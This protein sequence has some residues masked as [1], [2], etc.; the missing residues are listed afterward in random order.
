MK[1]VLFILLAC[2]ALTVAAQSRAPAPGEYV[3]EGG[4]G[5]LNVKRDKEKGLVFELE[6]IGANAHMCGL[7][8]GIR[9]D[10][11]VDL[12][13]GEPE[14]KVALEPKAE[15][16]DVR[17]IGKPGACQYY[18]GMRASFVAVY[19]KPPPGCAPSAVEKTR[20][21]FKALYDSRKLR[22][23]LA[24]LAP[25]LQCEKLMWFRDAA[26]VRSDLAVTQY[27]LDDAPGCLA[28]LKPLI[29]KDEAVELPSGGPSD[30]EHNE[31]LEKALRVN[32]RRCA[33][34]AAGSR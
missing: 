11:R 22:D 33:R 34:R 12:E 4:W 19:R 7:K 28:T 17:E 8:G 23:A 6:A 29:D 13:E 30:S 15:G 32:F 25:V 26:W 18:C 27:F 1:K 9:P 24:V 5:I 3:T 21:R 2:A 16:V 31:P 14:C 10:G 20:Q